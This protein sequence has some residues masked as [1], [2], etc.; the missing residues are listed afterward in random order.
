M[1][2]FFI[3]YTG[4]G[5][6]MKWIVLSVLMMSLIGCGGGGGSKP[7][8]SSPSVSVPGAISPTEPSNPDSFDGIFKNSVV[9]SNDIHEDEYFV[10][11]TEDENSRHVLFRELREDA[12]SDPVNVITST[13]VHQEHINGEWKT[14][15]AIGKIG[16]TVGEMLTGITDSGDIHAMWDLTVGSSFSIQRIGSVWGQVIDMPTSKRTYFRAL[17]VQGEEVVYC[18]LDREIAI[19][20]NFCASFSNG[21]FST[22]VKLG[23]GDRSP[24]VAV[25]LDRHLIASGSLNVVS[26][27]DLKDPEN[28]EKII[29]FPIDEGKTIAFYTLELT[30]EN[31]GV[32]FYEVDDIN[33]S[34]TSFN[35]A[36]EMNGEWREYP[37][38]VP[39]DTNFYGYQL[40]SIPRLKTYQNHNLAF[41]GVTALYVAAVSE[42]GVTEPKKLGEID[43]WGSVERNGNYYVIA[44][45]NK[46]LS[47][48]EIDSNLVMTKIKEEILPKNIRN[49][50]FG[51]GN[52]VFWLQDEQIDGRNTTVLTRSTWGLG[53]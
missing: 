12:L 37:D 13:L 36:I 9:V 1:L 21:S 30:Q 33:T 43:S 28:P 52:E 40:K 39:Y 46:T 41:M 22:P 20:D 19:D 53:F 48:F 10:L 25:G 6:R 24:S 8:P 45:K 27:F 18:W 31:N 29:D 15:E 44:V 49:I 42:T 5:K 50:Q 11:M 35:L 47:M 3:E 7:K 51:K 32:L 34:G 14:P 38:F 16:L 4:M 17:D 26:I 23:G 2:L